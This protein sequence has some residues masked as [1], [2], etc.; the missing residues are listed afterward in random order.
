MSALA[1]S[2]YPTRAR[3]TG[4][5]WMLGVGRVGGVAGALVGAALMGLG[6]QFGAVFSLLCVPAVIAASGVYLMMRR[7]PGDESSSEGSVA[8]I[9]VK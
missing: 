4:V 9:A 8:A 5:A 7:V 6:W 1:A 2:F 3:A